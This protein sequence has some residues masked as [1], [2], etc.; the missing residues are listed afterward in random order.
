MANQFCQAIFIGLAAAVGISA[1][2][3]D[4]DSASWYPEKAPTMEG[5]LHKNKKLSTATLIAKHQL[6]DPE[7]VAVDKDGHIYCSSLKDGTISQIT[8]G[9]KGDV[10]VEVIAVTSG[11]NLGLKLLPN[12]DL[13]A[14][15]VPLGLLSISPAGVVRCLTNKVDDGTPLNFPDDLD[16][17][18]QG[19]VYFSNASSKYNEFKGNRYRLDFLEGKAH[20]GLYRYDPANHTTKLLLGGLFFANGVALS[21]EEGYVLVSE[22][23]H[24]QITRYWLKGPKA[25][26]H[27]VFASNLPGSPDGITRDP[28]GDY[29]VAMVIPRKW[30]LDFL[31]HSPRIKHFLSHVPPFVWG[32]NFG[33]GLVARL[34]ERG[35]I[36]E[37]LQD[38]SGKIRCITNVVPWKEYLFLG[39]LESNAIGLYTRT[40]LKRTCQ[41]GTNAHNSIPRS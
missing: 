28:S 22:T 27:D 5:V 40:D 32:S 26:T 4:F 3:D 17:D 6:K 8:V 31:Q 16:V 7:D 10:I 11:V 33:Y 35:E 18:S 30:H 38:R 9:A 25:G 1:N 15:N 13:L 39:S 24:Y 2:A 12:G 19:R 41:S 37:T 14:C 29:W 36:V 23:G 21:K 34:N 20:G